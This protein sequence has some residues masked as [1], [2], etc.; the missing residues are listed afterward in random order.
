MISKTDQILFVSH[1][2]NR[3][4][5]TILLL[6]IIKEF[7]KQS[8]IPI[9][10]ILRENGV[11]LEEF[12]RIGSTYVWQIP[13]VPFLQ[14]PLL[15]PVNAIV[16]KIGMLIKGLWILYCVRKT[17]ITFSNTITNGHLHKKLLL[18]KCKFIT[19][20][21]ELE[22]SIR[23]LT[24]ENT[25]ETVL[26]QS[27]LL[28]AGSLAVKD[29]LINRHAVSPDKIQVIYSSI[30]ILKKDKIVFESSSNKLK[31]ELNI[32]SN[33]IIFGVAAENEWRKGFDLFAPLIKL[34]FNLYP[35]SNA[36]FIWIGVRPESELFF[37]DM[38]DVEKFEF[39]KKVCFLNHGG[40]YLKN[41]ALFDVH[42]LLSRE[43]PYPLVVLDAAT[44][45]IP[46]I[47]F[48][49]AGGTPEF[50]EEDCGF[51]VPYGDLYYWAKKMYALET[52][53]LLRNKMGDAATAKVKNRHNQTEATNKIIQ[54]I[55]TI[56]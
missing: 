10:I 29:N 4:G 27:S 5:A 22:V 43:D 15:M 39:Q 21:H 37:N 26:Q 20:I 13:S 46:T 23:A 3:S 11:L 52:D 16:S 51:C 28:L 25:L 2:A 9:K 53:T 19:Y 47:C 31:R 55:K 33:S 36:F 8:D 44:F 32:P 54:L 7:K 49:G 14:K 45:G 40:D 6:E 12:T 50:V 56:K 38:Y 1:K 42:L 24:N 18:L 34:Y 35:Q 41:M 30:P 48:K 17:T